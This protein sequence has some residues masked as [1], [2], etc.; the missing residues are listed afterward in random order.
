MHYKTIVLELLEQQPALHAELRSSG[1]LLSTMN[2]LAAVLRDLHLQ[3]LAD[4]RTARPSES[5]PL[6]SS[7]ALELAVHDLRQTLS[8]DRS[9]SFSLDE[10]MLYL[11]SRMRPV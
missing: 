2:Q 1:S 4:L 10:A 5:Q 3:T 9:E 8:P 6:L 11:T 7:E